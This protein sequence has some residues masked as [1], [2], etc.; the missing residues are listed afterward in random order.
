MKTIYT[1]WRVLG[2]CLLFLN[3]T[4]LL[5][6]LPS[7]F[8]D[9][10]TNILIK[11][12][13]GSG[14]DCPEQPALVINPAELNNTFG[15]HLLLVIQPGNYR[16]WLDKNENGF[17]MPIPAGKYTFTT[18]V[19]GTSNCETTVQE[20]EIIQIPT[21]YDIQF[22]QFEFSCEGQANYKIGISP[23]FDRETFG[24]SMTISL[25]PDGRVFEVA[26]NSNAFLLTL[27][28]GQYQLISESPTDPNC[29]RVQQVEV[30]GGDGV[31]VQAPI[32]TSSFCGS[33]IS[34][35]TPAC[36]SEI[37]FI[38]EATD[39]CG[40][41]TITNDYN[42]QVGS[43]FA[44]LFP[45]GPHELTFT[46]TDQAGNQSNCTVN[47]SISYEGVANAYCVANA[48]IAVSGDSKRYLTIDELAIT[49][50]NEE[51]CD[52]IFAIDPPYVSCDDVGTQL[53]KVFQKGNTTP[54]CEANITVESQY[55]FVLVC[56]EST[57]QANENRDGVCG[58]EVEVELGLE[59]TGCPQGFTIRNDHNTE[60][61]FLFTDFFSV[62]RHEVTFFLEKDGAVAAT[63]T[64]TIIIEEDP[65]G[66]ACLQP[67]LP[68]IAQAGST[69]EFNAIQESWKLGSQNNAFMAQEDDITFLSFP[70]TGDGSILAKVN[71]M[72]PT[73][74]A[75][76]MMR[77]NCNPDSRFIA[78]L[79]LP[80]SRNAYQ[81]HRV[82]TPG[83]SRQ[84][85]KRFRGSRPKWVKLKR[86]GNSF[87]S[88]ASPNGYS[89]KLLFK[90]T[91]PMGEDMQWGLMIESSTKNMY[92]TAT[93]EHIQ[94]NRETANYLVD[95]PSKLV[96]NSFQTQGLDQPE[97]GLESGKELSIFPNPTAG[98]V[99]VVLPNLQAKSGV[100]EVLDMSGRLIWKREI[101]SIDGQLMHFDW[102][103]LQAGM[104]LVAIK[105][106]GE[107]P[108]TQRLIIKP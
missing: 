57:Y 77:E 50:P 66:I 51:Y 44:D 68:E 35:T 30:L 103:T 26:E 49:T 29:Q 93:F 31:D 7:S 87:Y 80:F 53:V 92:A 106:E 59:S 73:A 67:C 99:S 11:Q 95:Q 79:L 65:S 61:G 108:S 33:H 1:L 10:S 18:S 90:T 43:S 4:S 83:T 19:I 39:N 5:L 32:F 37:H 104:Y 2:L 85:R 75:G 96:E 54:I 98:Q 69:F 45:L 107:S 56:N 71:Q 38:V 100:I 89:W 24:I 21:L 82:E 27:P 15:E 6:A 60:T 40:P 22:K 88:Y 17:T 81:R 36:F 46:A 13:E 74:R 8:T 91:L 3:L 97:I 102:R 101:E 9:C 14:G 12:S 55:E 64:E 72:S 58:A 47:M 42:D 62:G 28:A 52:E 16:I 94:I 70:M 25:L 63:C 105:Q 23:A 48:V 84:L 20:L 78:A 41:V 86:K 34:S 76:V